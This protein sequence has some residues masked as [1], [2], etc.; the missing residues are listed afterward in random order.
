MRISRVPPHVTVRYSQLTTV[1]R[2]YS[3]V[4]LPGVWH[5]L[6][7]RIGKNRAGN[8]LTTKKTDTET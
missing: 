8:L 3:T 6:A 5:K 4:T 1:L 2:A 7:I